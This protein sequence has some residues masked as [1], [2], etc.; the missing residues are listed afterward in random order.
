MRAAR[1]HALFACVALSL[2]VALVACSDN[3]S[4][5]VPVYHDGDSITATKGSQFVVELQANPS[6]GY[7]W[8]AAPNDTVQLVSSKQVSAEGAAPGA[9]GE[10]RMTFKAVKKGA[11]TLQFSYARSFE[12]DEPPANTATF[13]LEVI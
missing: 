1:F 9:A 12:P 11:S 13:D 7:S 8:Q 2:G 3:G 4:A 6:T 10:Q 5:S